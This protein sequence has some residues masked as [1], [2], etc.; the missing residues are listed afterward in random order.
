M[1]DA[2]F[3]DYLETT[4]VSN[5]TDD[6]TERLWKLSGLRIPPPEIRRRHS[7]LL[8]RST[9]FI[10]DIRQRIVAEMIRRM[11]PRMP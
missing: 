9:D 4:P 8:E 6:D 2:V 11:L 10:D 3:L 1:N 7:H 5:W